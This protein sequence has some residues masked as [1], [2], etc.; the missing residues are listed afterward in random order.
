MSTEYIQAVSIREGQVYLTS[1]SNNDDLPYHTWHCEGLSKVY[2]GGAAGAGSRDIADAV[3][4]CGTK[5]QSSKHCQ[6][7]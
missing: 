1:K 5:G 4:V 7:S 6:V 2:K 3:R